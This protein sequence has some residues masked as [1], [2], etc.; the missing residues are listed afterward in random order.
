MFKKVTFIVIIALVLAFFGWYKL[1]F[2]EV[3]VSSIKKDQPW[4]FAI[5]DSSSKNNVD[6]LNKIEWVTPQNNDKIELS[7]NKNSKILVLKSEL[8]LKDL[9]SIKHLLLEYNNKY[10]ISLYINNQLCYQANRFLITSETFEN[11]N[12]TINIYEHWTRVKRFIASEN[13]LSSLQEGNNSFVLTIENLSDLKDFTPNNISVSFLKN[14]FSPNEEDINNFEKNPSA[15]F[16]GSTLPIF[17]LN[18]NHQPIPDDPKIEA[19]LSVINNENNTLTGQKIDYKIKIERRGFTSQSF[20]KKSYGFTVIDS[21]DKNILD[22]PLAK[23]WVLYGPFADKSLIRN[24]LTYDLYRKMGHYSVKTAFVE[25]IINNNYQGIYI[26]TEKIN[27]SPQHLNIS[28]LKTDDKGITTGGYLLEID[29]N[30]IKAVFPPSN[31][32]SHVPLSYGLEIPKE[33]KTDS[34]TL[35][36]IKNQFNLFEEKMYYQPNDLFS[37][38][39]LNSF[40]DHFIISE[41]SKNIDAY[42]LSTYIYNP[43]ISSQ[44]PKFYMG[45]IWDY[46]FAFGLTNYNVGFNPE[47]FIYNSD[48][49]VPFWWEKLKKNESFNT[50]LVNRYF[51]LRKSS[52]SNQTIFNTID[53]LYNLCKVPADKNFKKWTVLNSKDFWPNYFLGKTHQEEII[54]LKDW[55][56]KRLLFLD[57][58]ILDKKTKSPL[59]Y[60]IQIRNNKEWLESVKSKASNK[61]ISVDEMIKRDAEYMVKN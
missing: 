47:G 14:T 55:V 40:V 30:N 21:L 3:W 50:A 56:T 20:S 54:Y 24:A 9:N 17:K 27:V 22:F 46:N 25:L 18:T 52:L 1:S 57:V 49:Y 34:L 19:D 44:T 7:E 8:E 32:T 41:L 16:S 15:T 36:L 58:E 28:N 29:R 42:R 4:S 59:Y 12:N 60:E 37:F 38:L 2:K 43:D 26:L 35:D 10:S 13:F 48:K 45:P 11:E 33:S 61:N 6:F 23:K 39:D 31:D 5:I 51:E 53:S